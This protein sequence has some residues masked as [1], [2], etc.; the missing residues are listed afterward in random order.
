MWPRLQQ[1]HRWPG[2]FGLLPVDPFEQ[3][4]Q[5]GLG[6][7]HFAVLGLGPDEVAPLEAL[8][9]QTQAIA[10]GPEQ[11]D[12]IAAPAAEDEDVAAKRVICQ[13]ALYLRGQAIEARAHV[14]EPA[15]IQMRV[16]RR[17]AHHGRRL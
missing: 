15:A 7:M 3:H 17:Q 9:E 6:E 14:G 10:A 8:G 13:R 16:A 11:L 1:R 5:L 12:D 4:R 2:A